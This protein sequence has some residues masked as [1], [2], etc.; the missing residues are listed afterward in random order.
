MTETTRQAGGL[1]GVLDDHRRSESERDCIEGV[2][3]TWACRCECDWYGPDRDHQAHLA[4]ALLAHLR[5]VAADEGVRERVARAILADDIAKGRVAD[6]F[7]SEVADR[8]WLRDEADAALAAFLDALG[9][10]DE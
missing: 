3:W 4:D 7:D 8:E 10:G 5:S 9:A 2:G 6:Y 1:A